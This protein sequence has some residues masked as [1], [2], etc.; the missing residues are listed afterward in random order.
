MAIAAATKRDLQTVLP[1]AAS[2]H[3]SPGCAAVV[4]GLLRGAGGDLLRFFWRRPPGARA[5]GFSPV[6]KRIG[7]ENFSAS[8]L[9]QQHSASLLGTK[10]TDTAY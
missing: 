4:A 7:S 8:A 1:R 6:P 3:G 5:H 10:M 2:V 9:V